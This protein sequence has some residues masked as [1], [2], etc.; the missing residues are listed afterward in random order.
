[1]EDCELQAAHS[2]VT[3]HVAVTQAVPRRAKTCQCDQQ[4][5]CA[6]R[7]AARL[8]FRKLKDVSFVGRH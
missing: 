7:T 2:D 1:M 5:Q 8:G 3:A 4:V 6:L